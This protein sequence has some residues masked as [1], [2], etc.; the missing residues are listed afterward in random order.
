MDEARGA[1]YPEGRHVP[2][3]LTI[4]RLVLAAA[5]FVVLTPWEYEKSP[6]AKEL[7]IDW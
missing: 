1:N 2:N 7:D 6:A 3:L 4:S 5:F